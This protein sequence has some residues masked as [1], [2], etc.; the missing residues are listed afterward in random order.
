MAFNTGNPIGSTDA[1]DLSD[2]AQNF[3]QAINQRN[4]PTWTD[5]L[6][7]TRKTVFGAFQEITYKAPVAYAAG[8]SFLTTDANKTVE[9]DGV[10]YA[11]LNSALPFTTSGTFS[12]D[13]DARFYPVQ[14]KNNVIRVTS[15]AAMEAYSAPVGYV[16]SLNAGGRSGTFDVV[17]GDF[18]TELA[19]DT[20]NGIYIG[21]ADDPTASTKVARRS[22][23]GS[24][25]IKWFGCVG[26]G[27]FDCTNGIQL[28]LDTYNDV[29][30]DVGDWLITSTIT[31]RRQSV[32]RM[33]GG[34][35]NLPGQTSPSRIMKDG[36]MT[37]DAVL[38]E[39]TGHLTG[40]A[41]IGKSGNTG[42]G[43]KL[44]GNAAKLSW[45]QVYDCGN[46]GVR[47][48]Y[49]GEYVNC[50]STALEHVKSYGNGRHGIYMHDGYSEINASSDTNAGTLFHCQGDQNGGDGI[51]LGRS[52]WWTIIN[53]L[54]A[55][56]GG[57]G[58]NVSDIVVA[59]DTVQECRYVSIFGGDYNEGNTAGSLKFSGYAGCLYFASTNQDVV[60]GG[61]MNQFYGGVG[62]VKLRQI[63]LAHLS[64]APAIS[65]T[66]NSAITAVTAARFQNSANPANGR[67][68][69]IKL[70]AVGSRDSAQIS[71]VQQTTDT[72]S[73]DFWAN[74][75]SEGL[76]NMLSCSPI[77]NA[78]RP[79]TDNEHNLGH[80]SFRWG[81]VYA[82]TGTINTSDEREKQQQRSINEAEKLC[83]VELKDS[84]KAYKWND[85]VETRGDGARWHFGLMAQRV[86]EVFEGHGLNAHEYGM[87]C[88]DEWEAEY[89]EEG[90]VIKE[91]GNRYGVRY[92]EIIM[93]I[94]AS[95]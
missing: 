16:F 89:S 24:V 27:V 40:G 45:F 13:D 57:W 31:V 70:G 6:G 51:R 80:P 29:E 41:V 72:D 71:S 92:D 3:D 1:R 25:N 34:I 87:L 38:I 36:S 18:S 76:R 46:D 30:A 68:I 94:L 59:P 9:D 4:A 55:G 26:D 48:G 61:T 39:T 47:V 43:V 74:Y 69:G 56:N 93:F 23:V 50:N 58:M 66:V 5:R 82:T 22:Y 12:G 8:I 2:N 95:S 75:A 37:G 67:G 65:S 88:Y 49:D 21:L 35:G 78:V 83:A 91:A 85:A 53:P 64:S 60:E 28:A 17:A 14:D 63:E 20:L 11:P 33:L 10:I 19:A 42:D 62:N 81:T 54:T 44:G 7:V 73:L 86:V 15:I 52:W 84:I 32:F 77:H 90:D 79:G